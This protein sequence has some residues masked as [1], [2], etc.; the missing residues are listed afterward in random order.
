VNLFDSGTNSARHLPADL[1]S[2]ALDSE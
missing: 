2:V 1:E